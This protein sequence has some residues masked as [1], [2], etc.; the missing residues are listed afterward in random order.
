MI[1][2]N[3]AAYVIPEFRA[4]FGKIPPCLLPIGNKK[5]VEY[6]VPMLRKAYD[7]QIIVSLPE[8]YRLRVCP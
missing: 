8:G 7:E 5:L 2:I 3:S 4:E 1:I 6:Q